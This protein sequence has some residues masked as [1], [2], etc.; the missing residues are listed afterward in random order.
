MNEYLTMADGTR[1]ENAYVVD[2]GE[3]GIAVYAAGL[4]TVREAWAVFGDPARTA[5]IHSYQYGE[6]AVWEG[7]T[8][9]AAIQAMAAAVQICLARED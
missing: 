5:V 3:A 2:L 4:G 9:P 1:V 6:E 7:Y 8:E